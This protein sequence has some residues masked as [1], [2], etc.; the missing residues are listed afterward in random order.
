MNWLST[1]N[2]CV[3]KR[4][5]ASRKHRPRSLTGEAITYALNEPRQPAPARPEHAPVPLTRRERQ[6]A[7]LIAQG[8]SNKD[9][10]ASL[11]VSQRTAESHAQHILTKLG[12]SSRAQVAA[13]ITDHATANA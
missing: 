13:W 11:V 6:V 1:P 12:F 10:A 4:L 5:Q 8:L 2:G 3:G 7:D 9:I